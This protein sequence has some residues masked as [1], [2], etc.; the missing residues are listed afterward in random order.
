MKTQ[1]AKQS[2]SNS[3]PSKHK[4][5]VLPRPLSHLGTHKMLPFGR[6]SHWS[7][8]KSCFELPDMMVVGVLKVMPR[9]CCIWML[10]WLPEYEDDVQRKQTL[11]CFHSLCCSVV[12][13]KTKISKYM[14][15]Y[16]EGLVIDQWVK[17]N[18]MQSVLI[19]LW[20]RGEIRWWF[21]ESN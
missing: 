11:I 13:A 15:V 7:H 16:F 8:V 6:W 2:S 12:M 19:W 14:A 3:T 1:N 18:I 20:D 17:L 10:W 5:K 9:L 21:S 4:D